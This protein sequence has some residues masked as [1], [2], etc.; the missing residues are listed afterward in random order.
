MLTGVQIQLQY[1]HSALKTPKGVHHFTGIRGNRRSLL[2]LSLTISQPCHSRAYQGPTTAQM[3][4]GGSCGA[5]NSHH[6][7]HCDYPDFQVWW[8]F[9]FSQ[10]LCPPL[11]LSVWES[12]FLERQWQGRKMI[13]NSQVCLR[14]LIYSFGSSQN[15][16]LTASS[17]NGTIQG[18]KSEKQREA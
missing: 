9:F 14:E 7:S 10:K 17:F 5:V 1:I 16:V 3:L 15:K 4:G 18:E 11:S 6:K 12:S 2:S 8:H 13:R